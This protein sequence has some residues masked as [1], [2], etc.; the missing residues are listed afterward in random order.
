VS[1]HVQEMVEYGTCTPGD[2]PSGTGEHAEKIDMEGSE[3]LATRSLNMR[4]VPALRIHLFA[5]D[6]PRSL[7]ATADALLDM[8]RIKLLL[9]L[10][11]RPKEC[12]SC[13]NRLAKRMSTATFGSEMGKVEDGIPA[14]RQSR[15]ADNG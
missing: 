8:V 7:V 13:G 3:G 11:S 5:L 6:L 2:G 12:Q 9:L 4:M 14:N 1:S 10:P 15:S